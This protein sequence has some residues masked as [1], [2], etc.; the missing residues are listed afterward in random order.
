LR[1]KNEFPGRSGMLLEVKNFLI[2]E[3]G[4]SSLIITFPGNIVSYSIFSESQNVLLETKRGVLA[5]PWT[6]LPYTLKKNYLEL[7]NWPVEVRIPGEGE[8][9]HKGI[10]GIDTADL[11]RV[12]LAMKNEEPSKRLGFR[13]T[14]VPGSSS[15]SETP[16]ELLE[17][18][19]NGT[20][21]YRMTGTTDDSAAASH[22]HDAGP[23][24]ALTTVF[25]HAKRKRSDDDK[26]EPEVRAVKIQKFIQYS[27]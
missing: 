15:S 22:V 21:L 20:A 27:A 11:K 12:Y 10:S 4:G 9:D 2:N 5:L 16:A 18:C 6:T 13:R 26:E 8:N 23:P 19:R 7:V 17:R 25:R 24:V 14:V 1:S 3:L